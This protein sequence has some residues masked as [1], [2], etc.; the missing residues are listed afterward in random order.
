MQQG[1]ARVGRFKK[2]PHVVDEIDKNGAP[3]RTGVELVETIQLYALY[4]PGELGADNASRAVFGCTSTFLPIA[5]TLLTRVNKWRYARAGRPAMPAPL[6]AYRWHLTT[7]QQRNADG[8]WWVP[9]LNLLP[10]GAQ[11]PA[12][13]RALLRPTEPLYLAARE[14]AELVKGGHVKPDYDA[15]GAAGGAGDDVP[16]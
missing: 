6:Y 1:I 14:F 13:L 5:Q 15:G 12:D 9:Q 10:L 3:R 8:T 2:I 4:A 7:V 11:P 16:F